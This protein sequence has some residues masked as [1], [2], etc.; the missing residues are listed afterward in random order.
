MKARIRLRA[1][2]S[3]AAAITALA[4]LV[5]CEGRRGPGEAPPAADATPARP[6]RQIA[7]EL[8]VGDPAPEFSLPGSD[9]RTYRLSEYHGR[10]AVVLAWFAKAFTG[11]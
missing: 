5:S 2:P 7:G 1:A 3:V 8:R 4:L 10:Q 6:E 11:G 9:G